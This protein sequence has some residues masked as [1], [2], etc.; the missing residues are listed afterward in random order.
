[1]ILNM[2]FLPDFHL[3]A[4]IFLGFIATWDFSYVVSVSRK[5]K[6]FWSAPVV[7]KL[8]SPDVVYF[9]SF[10]FFFR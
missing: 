8:N 5:S 1:M 10:S 3:S 7:Y 2:F 6:C 4:C 9:L